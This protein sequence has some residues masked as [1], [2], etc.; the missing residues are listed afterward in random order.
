[1]TWS[2]LRT[3]WCTSF[4]EVCRGRAS[5]RL[6][7]NRSMTESARRK[8]RRPLMNCAKVSRV[9]IAY[10]NSFTVPSE[11][12]T[13]QWWWHMAITAVTFPE[14]FHL[15]VPVD[16]PS[17]WVQWCCLSFLKD[18]VTSAWLIVILVLRL[19][20]IRTNVQV[21]CVLI[22]RCHVCSTVRSWCKAHSSVLLIWII[23]WHWSSQLYTFSDRGRF[24]KYQISVAG[25]NL[26]TVYDISS[27][28]ST[29]CRSFSSQEFE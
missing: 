16:C 20:W 1:M 7:R 2:P 29:C 14:K 11:M 18:A 27:C 28:S 10:V 13:G 6:Q 5:G 23:D 4:V 17:S 15:T 8:C 21:L 26:S 22:T 19:C 24:V 3:L 12:C 9:S 25:A